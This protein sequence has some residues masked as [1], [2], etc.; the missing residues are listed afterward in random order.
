ELASKPLLWP[1][2]PSARQRVH[3]LEEARTKAAAAETAA[4]RSVERDLHDGPQQD[5][6][7]IGMDLAAAERRLASGDTAAARQLID[8]ARVRNNQVLADLR[9]LA[10][11]I[12]P[13]T[14][15]QRGLLAALTV[16][17]ASA[18]V[19]VSLVGSVA[20]GDRFGQA[21][22]TAIYFAAAELLAN[23]T[24]HAQASRIEVRLDREDANLVLTVRDNGRG[25]AQILPGHGLAGLADRLA[26]VDGSLLITDTVA[27]M[28]TTVRVVV[29]AG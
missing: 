11:G 4:L 2:Q 26:G 16:T 21:T 25:G 27:G 14:L 15:A 5:L 19:P 3:Q 8:E 20:E 23:A 18:A 7:R 6:I 29:P 28:G 17:A 13:P 22:E 9:A 1:R 10:R 24:K 12:A